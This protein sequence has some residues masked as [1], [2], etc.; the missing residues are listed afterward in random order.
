MKCS[1]TEC[2]VL[3]DRNTGKQI[4]K[5][6]LTGHFDRTPLPQEKGKIDSFSR[7]EDFVIILLSKK[8][9]EKKKY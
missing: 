2:V 9:K 4:C 1:D 3:C 8:K 7:D 6:V 5:K